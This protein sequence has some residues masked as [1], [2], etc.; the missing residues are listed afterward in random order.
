MSAVIRFGISIETQLL[1]KFDKL[2]TEKGYTN[3]SEAIR[4]LIR[5][6]LVQQEFIS[7]MPVVG[8]A[9][10]VYDHEVSDIAHKL[11]H[12][13]HEFEDLIISSMHVHLPACNCM[14]VIAMKGPGNKMK[15]FA[16]Q[17]ISMKGVKHGKLTV[18]AMGSE[19]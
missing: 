10:I 15:Q 1:D 19:L 4:D 6:S 9:T 3:R 18:T 12:F 17:L 13:Q 8:T 16:D 7:D 14:E 5:D 11:T 2:I